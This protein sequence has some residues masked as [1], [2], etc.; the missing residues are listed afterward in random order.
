MPEQKLGLAL[1][2]DVDG[3]GDVDWSD[4]IAYLGKTRLGSRLGFQRLHKYSSWPPHSSF[5]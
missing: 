5:P 1:G 2:L 3:D 4:F